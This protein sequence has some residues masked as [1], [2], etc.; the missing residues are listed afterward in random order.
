[1]E[2]GPSMYEMQGPRPAGRA[3][4]P[5]TQLPMHCPASHRILGT[6]QR[7]PVTRLPRRFPES[8]PRRNPSSVVEKFYCQFSREHK[9]FGK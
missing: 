2:R 9:A 1:M 7:S 8:P 6:R 4:E 3:S 5:M